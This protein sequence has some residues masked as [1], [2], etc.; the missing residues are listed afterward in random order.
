MS[1][2]SKISCSE[3]C[4]FLDKYRRPI[5]YA[6]SPPEIVGLWGFILASCFSSTWGTALA[7]KGLFALA[8]SMPQQ[9]SNVDFTTELVKTQ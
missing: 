7:K 3:I 8:A 9:R 5:T 2:K 6:M 4:Q 1:D